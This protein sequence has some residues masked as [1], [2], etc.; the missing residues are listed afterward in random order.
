MYRCRLVFLGVVMSVCI[1]HSSYS[2]RRDLIYFDQVID[3]TIEK[4]ESSCS[5]VRLKYYVNSRDELII[6]KGITGISQKKFL[7]PVIMLHD[8]NKPH[9]MPMVE[10]NWAKN[11]GKPEISMSMNE[12]PYVVNF[13]FREWF[14]NLQGEYTFRFMYTFYPSLLLGKLDDEKKSKVYIVEDISSEKYFI[15]FTE[16]GCVDLIR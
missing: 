11:I 7:A 10:T 6:P 3:V 12:S 8:G 2:Q 16:N 13:D 4:L 15:R 1:Q 14:S 9:F 5:K